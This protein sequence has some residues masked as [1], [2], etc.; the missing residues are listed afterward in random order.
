MGE[1]KW[2]YKQN[3]LLKLDTI[4][5][6]MDLYW[7]VYSNLIKVNKIVYRCDYRFGNSIELKAIDKKKIYKDKQ[8]FQ[9]ILII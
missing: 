2:I 8:L 5:N 7:N 3:K 9:M 1:T 4:D 6:K